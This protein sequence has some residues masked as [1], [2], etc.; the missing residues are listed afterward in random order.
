MPNSLNMSVRRGKAI[1]I[2]VGARKL[3]QHSAFTTACGVGVDVDEVKGFLCRNRNNPGT[4]LS[5]MVRSPANLKLTVP[6]NVQ[7]VLGSIPP[8]LVDSKFCD[9]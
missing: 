6:T 3:F 7:I 8:G 1:N 9:Q 5:I 4:N 2:G